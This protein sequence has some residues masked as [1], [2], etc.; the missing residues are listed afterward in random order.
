MS[1]DPRDLSRRR[2]D[3][4]AAVIAIAPAIRQ[5]DQNRAKRTITIMRIT[6]ARVAW[7]MTESIS[8]MSQATK[9]LRK[10]R[11]IKTSSR[12]I[13]HIEFLEPRYQ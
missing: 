6:I 12:Y 4:L 9:N 10:S 13:P 1:A 5:H 2:L 11:E 7:N 8:S 3:Y